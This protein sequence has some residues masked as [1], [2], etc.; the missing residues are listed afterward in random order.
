MGNRS[1][2][3]RGLKGRTERRE[4]CGSYP[5]YVRRLVEEWVGHCLLVRSNRRSTMGRDGLW[6][7]SPTVAD[8]C[9][10]IS[11]GFIEIHLILLLNSQL[12]SHQIPYDTQLLGHVN[13]STGL[14]NDGCD[15]SN[16]GYNCHKT[17][18]Y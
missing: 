6:S 11:W 8:W 15:G 17:P 4:R 2:K 5:I 18:E 7:E 10:W 14:D 12:A 9:D 16:P 1:R 13:R 3:L